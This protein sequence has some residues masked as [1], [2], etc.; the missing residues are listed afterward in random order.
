MLEE[1]SHE[2]TNACFHFYC[3]YKHMLIICKSGFHYDVF[4]RFQPV[5]GS[6]PPAIHSHPLPLA[7][8]S[9]LSSF[10]FHSLLHF[11]PLNT[12]VLESRGAFPVCLSQSRYT[13]QPKVNSTLV[14]LFICCNC[15]ACHRRICGCAS[16]QPG[17]S[18]SSL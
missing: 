18:T 6:Y 9:H 5:S 10:S 7:Y 13:A 8:S 12:S 3:F 17:V 16:S 14:L 15:A 11:G 1:S 2:K 4:T